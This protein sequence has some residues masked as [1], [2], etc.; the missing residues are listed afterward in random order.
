MRFITSLVSNV[1]VGHRDGCLFIFHETK[2]KPNV[3]TLRMLENPELASCENISCCFIGNARI[4][5]HIVMELFQHPVRMFVCF[6]G[7]HAADV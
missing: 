1:G 6:F 4:G 5:L 2:A 7:V 3:C